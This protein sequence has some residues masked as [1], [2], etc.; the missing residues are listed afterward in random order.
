VL[1][2]WWGDL[3]QTANFKWF[4]GDKCTEGRR[5]DRIRGSQISLSAAKAKEVWV[6]GV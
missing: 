6:Y 4:V 1:E 5:T 3:G 2:E